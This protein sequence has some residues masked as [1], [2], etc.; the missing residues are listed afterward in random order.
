MT[1]CPECGNSNARKAFEGDDIILY[2]GRCAHEENISKKNGVNDLSDTRNE[3]SN[4]T[5]LGR[6]LRWIIK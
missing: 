1:I 2:C 3:N 5:G 4:E 6:F